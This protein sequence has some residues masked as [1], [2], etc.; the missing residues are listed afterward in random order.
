MKNLFIPCDEPVARTLCSA[1]EDISAVDLRLPT[2]LAAAGGRA[3]SAG[4]P[5]GASGRIVELI[6]LP[7]QSGDCSENEGRIHR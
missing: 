1:A 2:T 4:P 3:G 7:V 5:D 6:A